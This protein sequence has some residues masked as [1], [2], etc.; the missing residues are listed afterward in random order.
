MCFTRS[1]TSL[2]RRRRKVSSS[3]Q[4]SP[5]RILAK[6]DLSRRTEADTQSFLQRACSGR[7]PMWRML[8][9]KRHGNTLAVVVR[10]VGCPGAG[11]YSLVEMALNKLAMCWRDFPTAAAACAALAVLD[12]K[13]PTAPATPAAAMGVR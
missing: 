13:P 9:M 6:L 11:P 3:L 2:S 8:K 10:W 12:V 5:P 1:T 4:K 7:W